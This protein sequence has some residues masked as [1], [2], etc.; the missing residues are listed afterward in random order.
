MSYCIVLASGIFWVSFWSRLPSIYEVVALLITCVLA[1]YYRRY[2]LSVFLMGILYAS[3]SGYKQLSAQLPTALDHQKAIVHATVVGLPTV[4]RRSTQLVVDA[5]IS[6]PDQSR[7]LTGLIRLTWYNAPKIR[8]GDQWQLQ[9]KLKSLRGSIN[10]YVR[11]YHGFLFSRQLMATGQVIGSDDSVIKHKGCHSFSMDCLRYN[12]RSLLQMNLSPEA[13]GLAV[14]LSVGDKSL[15][16]DAQLQMLRNT[17]TIHLLAISG[18][19]VGLIAL[20]GLFLGMMIVRL[21]HYVNPLWQVLWVAYALSII[22]A[23]VYSL[24]AGFTLPTQRAL[25][26]IIV[27]Y[28]SRLIGRKTPPGM[29]VALA[30][31]FVALLDPLAAIQPGFWL[32]FMAVSLLLWGFSGWSSGQSRWVSAI[33]SQWIMWV[34]LSIPGFWLLGGV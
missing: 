24:M 4:S 1:A 19:H 34:G 22:M 31:V 32:S 11:D 23:I 13:A 9:V 16:S 33:K 30:L 12:T 21:T 5:R 27:F 15:M 10:P 7:S 28:L 26:M 25:I 6:Q 14:A 2:T 8:P 29:S 17:G 18:L 20:I 3:V